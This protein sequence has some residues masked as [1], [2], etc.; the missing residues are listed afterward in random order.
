MKTRPI[1]WSELRQE[2]CEVRSGKND[3][4]SRFM[5]TGENVVYDQE[6]NIFQK[7]CGVSL[8]NGLKFHGTAPYIPEVS[9]DLPENTT[10][11]LFYGG[12]LNRRDQLKVDLCSLSRQR[13]VCE[14]YYEIAK[15]IKKEELNREELY[16]KYKENKEIMREDMYDDTPYIDFP[17][18][19]YGS[20]DAYWDCRDKFVNK[21]YEDKTLYQILKIGVISIA[22]ERGVKYKNKRPYK[23]RMEKYRAKIDEYRCSD[24]YLK[25]LDVL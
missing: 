24:E 14:K 11:T 16:N 1:L 19:S 15:D 6:T 8:S 2:Y 9:D 25:V 21:I 23:E 5:R 10:Y 18:L 4:P 7:V 3:D 20:D 17:K 22:I 13:F 12:R